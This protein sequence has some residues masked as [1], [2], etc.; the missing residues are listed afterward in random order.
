MVEHVL[1]EHEVLG[2]TP[3]ASTQKKKKKNHTVQL[4]HVACHVR[5]CI[6]YKYCARYLTNF[7]F[8][9]YN[10]LPSILHPILQM[11]KHEKAKVQGG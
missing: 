3:S 7:I 10:S 4:L 1:S 11:R 8:N 9:F 5:T 6:M 2:L